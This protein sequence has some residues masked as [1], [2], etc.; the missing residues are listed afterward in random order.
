MIDTES[1]ISF[2]NTYNEDEIF[3]KRCYELASDRKALVKYISSFD[4]QELKTRK[5]ILPGHPAESKLMESFLFKGHGKQ[6]IF[7][8]KHNR[9]T[10]AFEHC[11]DFF[12]I[13]YVFSGECKNTIEGECFS[14]T[15]GSLCF[16]APNVNHALEVFSD[17]IVINILI[18]KTT[19][20]D[21]FFNLLTTNNILSDF[22]L[23]NIYA[24]KPIE[25]IIFNMG[26]DME[27]TEKIF[28]MLNEQSINDKYST[29]IM[30]YNISI[31]FILLIRKYGDKQFIQHTANDTDKH[32][33]ITYIN[34]HFRTIT[35]SQVA[36][37]FSVSIAHCSRLIKTITGKKFTDLVRDIRLHHSQ[38]LLK[39][40]NMKIYDISY[41]L[42]YENP[43]TFIRSFR[44]KYGITPKQY[45]ET[46]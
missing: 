24:A 3:Y 43:E 21:I 17:S 14:L 44:K 5:L 30:D 4:L 9:Y 38:S 1:I 26:D 11:H 36:R 16:I 40:T 22:F 45:R 46:K 18:R 19:F 28:A 35:L 15:A 41:S 34:E 33:Y 37:Y 20:D 13:F 10:P 29:R 39:T 42:G 8:T 6:N 12:E 31:F 2:L 32:R 27:M 23:G 7:L 25:Y